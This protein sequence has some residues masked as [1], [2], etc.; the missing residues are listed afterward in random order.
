MTE[1][2]RSTLLFAQNQPADSLY[3]VE[4]GLVKLTRTNAVGD[5]IIVAVR[6]GNDL[7][8]EEVLATG[9][10]T[11]QSEAEVLTNVSVLRIS[12][13][14]LRKALLAQPWVA[15]LVTYLIMQKSKLAD[16]VEL[17]C[18]HDVEYRILYYL[19]ELCNLVKPQEDTNEYQIPITQ[20]ELADLIGAT[21]ETT[22]TT[23]NQLERRGLIRLSRRMLTVPSPDKLRSGLAPKYKNKGGEAVISPPPDVQAHSWSR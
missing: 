21:R 7:V 8:G 23:L 18:L 17:L 1:L 19:A 3:L 2:R 13:E 15:T 12:G 6:G 20:L 10:G 16:K 5:R 4:S 9:D 11:F 14:A 22:S